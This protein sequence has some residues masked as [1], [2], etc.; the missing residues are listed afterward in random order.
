MW[1]FYKIVMASFLVSIENH[2]FKI[3][4]LIALRTRIETYLPAIY[5]SFLQLII[6]FGISSVNLLWS[7]ILFTIKM[8]LSCSLRKSNISICLFLQ[9]FMLVWVI[10][11]KEVLKPSLKKYFWWSPKLFRLFWNYLINTVKLVLM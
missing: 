5:S 1:V 8:S 6:K 11:R 3:S 9:L 4:N 10:L 2:L 7:H